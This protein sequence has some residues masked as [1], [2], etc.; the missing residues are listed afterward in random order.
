MWTQN[1]MLL[2]RFGS[3]ARD[4]PYFVLL[5]ELSLSTKY[6]NLKKI[7]TKLKEFNTEFRTLRVITFKF[8]SQA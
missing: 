2:F 8:Y 5:L 3:Y 6:E 7:F 4:P 1:F